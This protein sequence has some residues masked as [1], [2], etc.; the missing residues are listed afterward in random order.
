M[1]SSFIIALEDADDQNH[2][3]AAAS[4]ESF[5]KNPRKLITT[6]YIFDETITF[7]KRRISYDKA[8]KVGRLL[9]SSPLVEMAHIS[10]EDFKQGWALFLNYH[11]KDFSFTDCVSFLVMKQQGIKKAF[12][13]DRH[14]KQ[15]GFVVV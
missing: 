12:T 11:D 1:D 4:W 14:F 13:F 3:T 2:E 7:L 15:M 10:E 8:A 9:L 5:K 6:A